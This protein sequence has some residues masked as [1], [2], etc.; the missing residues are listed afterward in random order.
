[1]SE[2]QDMTVSEAARE[3]GYH[4]HH[5]YRLLAEGRLKARQFNRVWIIK[6]SEVERLKAEQ[7]GGRL[8]RS[9]RS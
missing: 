6:R 3:L 2:N 9:D 5:V 4:P 7:E 1:M 8:P